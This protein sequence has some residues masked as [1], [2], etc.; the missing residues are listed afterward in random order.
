MCGVKA[1]HSCV[2]RGGEHATI[3]VMLRAVLFDL[4]DTL[5][6][7]QSAA[8]AAVLVWAAEHGITDDDVSRRWSE[9]SEVHYARY[10]RRQL[11]FAQQRRE[12]VRAFLGVDADDKHADEL[13]AGYLQRYEDG[14]TLFGDAVPALRRARAAGMTVA[15]FT[16]GD[17]EHQRFK[18][19]KFG[20]IDEV[21][22]V[23]A[24]SSLSAGKPDRR[25]FEAALTHVHANP[26]EALMVGNSLHKDVLG[27]L[28]AGLDAVLLDRH[29]MHAEASVQ[30]I[31][32]LDELVFE[33]RSVTHPARRPGG[34]QDG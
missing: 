20:I 12:R 32:T 22:A 16:N 31:R 18:L 17:E 7:Q 30:R 34:A 33:E 19:E 24:S 1:M 8:A 28:D 26:D 21:D 3:R 14:W 27:A 25:A 5:V 15:V 4:D 6:D 2:S 11:S 13:F 9:I 23:I 10:Q 29:D